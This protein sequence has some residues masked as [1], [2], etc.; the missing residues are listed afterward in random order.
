MSVLRAC[1]WI[2]EMYQWLLNGDL[3][4]KNIHRVLG[5][6]LGYSVGAIAAFERFDS[7]QLVPGLEV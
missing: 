2:V 7:G 5:M 4:E 6:L 1:E 3:P